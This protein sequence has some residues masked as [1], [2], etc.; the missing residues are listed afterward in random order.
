MHVLVI[1]RYL[2]YFFCDRIKYIC[3]L[4]INNNTINCIAPQIRVPTKLLNVYNLFNCVL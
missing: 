3:V 1:C 2:S 4:I